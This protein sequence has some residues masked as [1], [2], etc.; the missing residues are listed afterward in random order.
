MHEAAHH[1]TRSRT[2]GQV[3]SR[4]LLHAQVSGQATLGKEVGWELDSTAKASTNHS[5]TH[6]TVNALDTFTLVD[7]AQS[8]KRVP[9]VVLGTDGEE[10]RV[11][12]QAC[13]DKEERRP[14]RGTDDTGG[15]ACEDVG[16]KGLNFGIAIDGRSDVGADRLI[17]AK[18]TTVQQDLINVLKRKS[19]SP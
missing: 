19:V 10:R 15:S 12:L 14:G 13:L 2:A 8:I 18:T 9:V 7:L 6:T 17:E 1:K 16:S 4:S 11:R 5:S 3:Q